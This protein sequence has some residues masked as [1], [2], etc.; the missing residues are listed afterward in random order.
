MFLFSAVPS[1]RARH[2]QVQQPIVYSLQEEECEEL[3]NNFNED[4]FLSLHTLTCSHVRVMLRRAFDAWQHNVPTMRFEEDSASEDAHALVVVARTYENPDFIGRASS[5]E[6]SISTEHCWFSDASF[7]H[8]IQSRWT[9]LSAL[10]L[11]AW[12]I[13]TAAAAAL[14]C[15]RRNARAYCILPIVV[16]VVFPPLVYWGAMRPCLRCHDFGA[17]LLHEIGHVLGLLHP[18][19]DTATNMCG[20]G[21]NASYCNNTMNVPGA[22]PPIMWSVTRPRAS[23]CLTQDDI[24]G[25]RTLHAPQACTSPLACYETAEFIGVARFCMAMIYSLVI[26]SIVV[27]VSDKC[28]TRSA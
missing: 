25:A 17:L 21:A 24:D 8:A 3:L 6:I 22:P 7:C 11:S 9:I 14:L 5:D 23:Y 1:W 19:D 15:H 20:C 28:A 4:R 18:D 2:W 12:L 13:G 16:C 10:L 27:A 26:A